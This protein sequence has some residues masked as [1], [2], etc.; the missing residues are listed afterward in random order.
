L[1]HGLDCPDSRW[2]QVDGTC[3]RGNE[4]SGFIKCGEILD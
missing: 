2:G 4:P 1:G 3:K